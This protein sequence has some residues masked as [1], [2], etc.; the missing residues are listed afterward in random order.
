MKHTFSKLVLFAVLLPFSISAQTAGDSFFGLSNVHTIK[1]YFSQPNYWDSLVAAY[2]GDYYIAADVEIDG[3]YIYGIGA[4]FKGNSSYNNPNIKKSMKLD[5]NE[6]V[7]GQDYDGL[8]K[9]NL[10][11]GFK[12]PTFLREKTALEFMISHNVPA[13]RCTYANVYF[14]DTL[15]GFYMIVEEIDDEF[16]NRWF[17]NNKGNLFK[18]DPT[19]DLKWFGSTPSS[20]YPKYELHNNDLQNDWT[21]LVAFIN[22]VNNSPAG[23]FASDLDTFF[24]VDRYI[25]YWATTNLFVNLDS[26][27]GSGHNYYLYHDS[28]ANKFE[29]IVWDINESYGV[30]TMGMNVSQLESLAVI[31]IPSPATNRPLNNRMIQDVN[32]KQQ[33]YDEVCDL[34]HFDFSIWNMEWYIDSLANVIRPHVY[35]DPN[36]FYSNQNFEDNIN[37]NITVVGPGGGTMPGLKSFLINRRISIASELAMNGCTVDLHQLNNPH[38][39]YLAYPNPFT[40]EITLPGLPYEYFAYDLS[41]M[42][43]RCVAS[44]SF[45]G[46]S[47]VQLSSDLAPGTYVLSVKNGTFEVI[48]NQKLFKH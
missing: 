24:N 27:M 1:L 45:Y 14:N 36:K 35:A 3:N 2:N 8:K 15:W 41:D 46:P 13:P 7:Q 9:L 18:G 29:F 37:T 5:F 39:G 28:V 23:T 42:T 21:D 20:Y 10:N 32:L 22:V 30:F 26:Y 40:S 43:G 12:D 11:N 44:G 33:L 16:L 34:I 48:V 38:S 19:G 17:L 31:H 47:S 4:K 25:K 6:F